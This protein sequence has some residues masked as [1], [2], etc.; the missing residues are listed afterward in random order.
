M[1]VIPLGLHIVA[2]YQR[3]WN[4]EKKSYF[5]EIKFPL[6]EN[7]EWQCMQF[8][9]NSNTL[10]EILIPLN[11]IQIQL[12]TDSSE[13]HSNFEIEF[14]NIVSNSNLTKF[15][16]KFN[17]IQTQLNWIEI[18]WN[19]IKEKGNGNCCAMYWKYAYHFRQPWVWCSKNI[20]TT[21]KKHKSKKMYTFSFHSSQIPKQ[22]LFWHDKTSSAP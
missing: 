19:S 4:D 5:V 13:L 21:P 3:Q 20:Y 1:H 11:W 22:N 10:H 9:L 14:Q 7:I 8:E 15:N 6:N 18:Q 2:H 16:S 17:R 12:S